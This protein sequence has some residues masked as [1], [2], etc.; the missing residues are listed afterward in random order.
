MRVVEHRNRLPREAVE[1][2]SS[3]IFRTQMV[4]FRGNLVKLPCLGPGLHDLQRYLLSLVILWYV[5]K[6]SMA[7]TVLE[8]PTAWFCEL[9]KEAN[10][11]WEPGSGGNSEIHSV[12][13]LLFK[14]YI[15][16][17]RISRIK[18]IA[19]DNL[20]KPIR[21]TTWFIMKA[22]C[23]LKANTSFVPNQRLKKKKKETRTTIHSNTRD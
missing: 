20:Q 17:F 8:E 22:R 19:K 3:K 6:T 12:N 7:S 10:G 4:T 5:T 18:Y 21:H 2:L 15:S 23:H 16:R 13:T 14:C 1:S 9:Q 11:N